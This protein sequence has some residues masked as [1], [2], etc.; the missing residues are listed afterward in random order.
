MIDFAFTVPAGTISM[1][2]VLVSISALGNAIVI[3]RQKA[4][5]EQIKFLQ[6][7]VTHYKERLEKLSKE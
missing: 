2:D 5:D 7:Q 4:K 6:D 3:A 1:S